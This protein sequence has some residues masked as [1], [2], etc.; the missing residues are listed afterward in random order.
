MLVDG[1]YVFFLDGESYSPISTL[2]PRLSVGATLLEL[3]LNNNRKLLSEQ[4]EED[5]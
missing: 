1:V 2:R 4:Q 3:W 5:F